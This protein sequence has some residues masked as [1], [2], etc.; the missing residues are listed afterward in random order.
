MSFINSK[1]Q[2]F[3]QGFTGK[4]GEYLLAAL[5]DFSG[6]Y[7]QSFSENPYQ[8]AFNEGKRAVALHIIQMLALTEEDTRTLVQKYRSDVYSSTNQGA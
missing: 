5:L 8:T 6:F 4:D 2:R 3:K 7:R 1:H